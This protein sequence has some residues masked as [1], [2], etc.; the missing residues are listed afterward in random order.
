MKTGDN[1]KSKNASWSFR[2]EVFK[3]FDKHIQKS[4]PMY[5]ECRSLFLFLSDFFIQEN[6]KIYDLGSSTGTFLNMI[7]NRHDLKKKKIK[8]I[9]I[10]SVEEMVKYSK[11]NNSKNQNILFKNYNILKQSFKNSCIISSFYTIQF[12]SPS[13]RQFLINKIYKDL[14]WGGAFFMVEKVRG[15][16]ARFQDILNQ[17]YIDYKISKG[18]SANEIISKSRSLKSVLEP[19]SSKGNLDMLKRSGFKDITT[20]FKY[21]NFEGFLA[22]K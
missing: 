16:D 3:N 7:S 11:R 19:F 1:I 17:F 10:D 12:I 2:G 4:V 9:G 21:G 5:Q 15:P 6:S 22:I 18:Y 13:K 20:V 8:C 14:N